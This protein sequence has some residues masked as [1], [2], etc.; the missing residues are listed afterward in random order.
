MAL[1]RLI[2]PVLYLLTLGACSVRSDH[3]FS[4]SDPPSANPEVATI[5]ELS[6]QFSAAYMRGDAAA[7]AALYTPDAVI[8]PANS[9]MVKG[10]EAIQRYWT[11][12]A[13]QRIT[14]HRVTHTEIRID[15]DHAYD[16]GVYEV[17]G[18]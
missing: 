3:E 5:A 4:W 6:R 2:A 15:G 1:F 10:R 16:Y 18:E 13:G 12:P 9:E 14:H 11:L 8:F 17:S 7:M